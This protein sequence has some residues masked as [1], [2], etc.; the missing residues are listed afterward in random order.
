M[1]RGVVWGSRVGRGLGERV[2]YIV[3]QQLEWVGVIGYSA[4]QEYGAKV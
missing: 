2:M 3:L 4:K 1:W